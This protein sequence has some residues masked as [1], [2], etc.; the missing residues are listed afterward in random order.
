MVG[1]K[2]LTPLLLGGAAIYIVA[3]SGIL[4]GLG[5]VGEGV[6][7]AA[8]GLGGGV[9]TAAR[10]LGAGVSDIAGDISQTT[11]NLADFLNPLGALGVAVRTCTTSGRK[12]KIIR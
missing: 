5:G 7:D 6:S 3:T 8:K 2:D 12:K 4:K 1:V 11:G 10:G 9:S